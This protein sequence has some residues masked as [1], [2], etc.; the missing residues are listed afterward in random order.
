MNN[1]DLTRPPT[2]LDRAVSGLAWYAPELITAGVAAAA[3]ATVWAPLGFVSVAVGGWIATD[4]IVTARRNGAARKAARLRADQER[5][6][7]AADTTQPL[8]LADAGE[9]DGLEVAG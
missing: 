2:V 5:L 6:D 1:D 8:P 9:G 7:Q 4:R 3:A